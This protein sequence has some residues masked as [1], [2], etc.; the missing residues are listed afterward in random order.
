MRLTNIV[1]ISGVY[2]AVAVKTRNGTF[3]NNVSTVL[4]QPFMR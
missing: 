1:N 4:C 3:G 2:I